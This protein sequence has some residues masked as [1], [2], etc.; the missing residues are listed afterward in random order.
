MKK[1]AKTNDN[2]SKLYYLV[3]AALSLVAFVVEPWLGFAQALVV[4]V[5]Y[6][7]S[8]RSA[9]RRRAGIQ[10][11][12]EQMENTANS[13]GKS[14]MLTMPFAMMVFR[15]DTQEI[16]WS[17]DNF[18][19]QMGLGEELFNSKLDEALPE[20]SPRWLMEGK[21]ECPDVV[22]VGGSCS[23]SSAR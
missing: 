15:P 22:A 16:L 3:G 13:A 17:N 19:Q 10:R 11:Y 8:Q 6:L 18:Q 12:V 1:T 20:F 7:A 9:K 4:G 21:P 23:M 2:H 14:S 5:M